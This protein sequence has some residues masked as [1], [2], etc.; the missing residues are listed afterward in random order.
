MEPK[1]SPQK[2]KFSILKRKKENVVL[3]SDL[4]TSYLSWCELQI[5][6]LVLSEFF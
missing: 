3:P 1:K 2:H 5:V 6:Y 4:L